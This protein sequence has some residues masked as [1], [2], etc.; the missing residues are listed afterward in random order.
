MIEL[1]K[2]Y[3]LFA[4]IG[5]LLVLL[6]I[7]RCSR[8]KPPAPEIIIK[9][10]T[11]WIKK[12]SI[13]FT[14][15]LVIKVAGKSTIDTSFIPNPN[16]GKLLTQYNNLLLLYFQKNVTAD[17]LKLGKY[18][19]VSVLDTVTKNLIS[20]RTYDYK[21]I[22]PEV[23]ETQI[24]PAKLRN[25]LYIGGGL[26]GNIAHPVSQFNA[27]LML[28]TKKEQLYGVF[29]GMDYNGQVNYGIQSYWKIHI[30]K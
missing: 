17:T 10:D 27:G 11:V 19:T 8:P 14:K 6:L 9:R 24:I 22:F 29:A 2:K 7:G 13:I 12:D 28:K 1:I 18:G 3:F 23:K 21:L 20:G 15:P 30:G 25:Q 5:I 4:I 26:Q 16:Y